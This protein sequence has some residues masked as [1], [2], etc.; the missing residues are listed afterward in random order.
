[1]GVPKN[2]SMRMESC[3]KREGQRQKGMPRKGKT[4]RPVKHE[5]KKTKISSGVVDGKDFQTT[6]ET[7]A[8]KP[9]PSVSQAWG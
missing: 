7:L 8:Q 5:R 6:P 1:M 2:C 3:T 4:A 9:P